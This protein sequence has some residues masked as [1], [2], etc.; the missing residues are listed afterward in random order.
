MKVF[1]FIFYLFIQLFWQYGS[2]CMGSD[3]KE[4]N[5]Q[6]NIL[7]QKTPEENSYTVLVPLNGDKDTKMDLTFVMIM[8]KSLMTGKFRM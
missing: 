1:S 5:L 7:L 8:K 3:L 4:A 6:N 2:M